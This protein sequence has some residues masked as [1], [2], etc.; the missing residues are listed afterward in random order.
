MGAEQLLCDLSFLKTALLKI[1]SYSQESS[2]AS[3]ATPG[4]TAA[5]GSSNKPQKSYQ[6]H[7]DDMII[8]LEKQLQI[9]VTSPDALV[10]SYKAMAY[11]PS[12]L[13]FVKMMDLKGIP[14]VEQESYLDEYGVGPNDQIRLVVKNQLAEEGEFGKKLSNLLK[15]KS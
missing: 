13:H 9:V 3:T 5:N 7:L 2:S 4:S 10:H 15:I 6:K 14:K 1:P 12:P 8:P 11:Q